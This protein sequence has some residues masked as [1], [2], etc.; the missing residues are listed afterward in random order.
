MIHAGN[1]GTDINKIFSVQYF[2]ASHFSGD[3]AS[4]STDLKNGINSGLITKKEIITIVKSSI[5]SND[6]KL[7]EIIKNCSIKLNTDDF[8]KILYFTILYSDHIDIIPILYEELEEKRH[9]CRRELLIASALTIQTEKW[10]F[11]GLFCENN[12]DIESN[13][14]NY[15]LKN[16]DR[17]KL[18]SKVFENLLPKE[19]ASKAAFCLLS[20]GIYRDDADT[21]KDTAY[22]SSIKEEF[23]LSKNHF[24]TQIYKYDSIKVLKYFISSEYLSLEYVYENASLRF[25]NDSKDT[26][27]ALEV[28]YYLFAKS[29]TFDDA[30]CSEVISL[31]VHHQNYDIFKKAF[32]KGK[33]RKNFK[34]V[35]FPELLRNESWW[36]YG[37][38]L[39]KNILPLLQDNEEYLHTLTANLASSAPCDYFKKILCLLP[40][41]CLSYAQSLEP[42][43]SS[44]SKELR[45]IKAQN[46][47]Y[48][49][50]T[51]SDKEPGFYEKLY[52]ESARTNEFMLDYLLS[53]QSIASCIHNFD[54]IFEMGCKNAILYGNPDGLR[55]LCSHGL[56]LKQVL[57]N[58]VVVSELTDCFD[59]AGEINFFTGVSYM[60][61]PEMRSIL[62]ENNIEDERLLTIFK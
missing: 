60:P 48:V 12:K 37:D 54:R 51:S 44:E 23:E 9:L 35:I 8:V 59:R 40:E 18:S 42:D 1:I 21:L 47:I 56:D 14:V 7:Y 38:F 55:V 22:S 36:E 2:S 3:Y 10:D 13:I 24:L 16:I 50:Q 28:L 29:K 26:F 61:N 58:E 45:S 53:D 43:L 15:Y 11:L 32:N 30:L 39:E 33:R 52:L 20:Y 49:L 31:A 27:D 34:T 62:E 25:S 46:A 57:S 19:P 6:L 4:F 17:I 41:K 5:L